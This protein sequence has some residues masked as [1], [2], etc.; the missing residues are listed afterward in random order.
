MSRFSTGTWGSS[1]HSSIH[2]LTSRTVALCEWSCSKNLVLG[3]EACTCLEGFDRG[4]S[5][6]FRWESSR[7]ERHTPFAVAIF[8]PKSG[9]FSKLVVVLILICVLAAR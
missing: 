3:S 8:Y 4:Q 6:Y 2:F 5:G 9:C 1:N 7:G